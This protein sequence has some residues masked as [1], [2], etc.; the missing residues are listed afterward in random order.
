MTDEIRD[1]S[2]VR[3][4]TKETGALLLAIGGLAAA[5]G[6]ASCSA[7]PIMLGSI[8]LS[9]A[10]LAGVAIFAAPHRMALVGAAVICL[11]G[12]ATVLVRY[13]RALAYAPGAACGNPGV[14][15]LVIGVLTLGGM[16]AVA[17]YLFA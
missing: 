4:T 2:R 17:G 3:E 6:A 11:I 5:F 15:P 12:A 1:V 8:G 9:S 16:L 13:R 14:T 10:W 7:I